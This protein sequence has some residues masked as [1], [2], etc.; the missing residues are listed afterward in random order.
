MFRESSLFTFP[1]VYQI[2]CIVVKHRF[3]QH[4]LTDFI[5]ASHTT[6]P[7]VLLK[8]NL[9]A[10]LHRRISFSRYR[11]IQRYIKGLKKIPNFISVSRHGDQYPGFQ[12]LTGNGWQYF[13]YGCTGQITGCKVTCSCRDQGH[14]YRSKAAAGMQKEIC[15]SI[16]LQ[17]ARA[18]REM[19]EPEM[20]RYTFYKVQCPSSMDSF[21]L[22]KRLNLLHCE[23][24]H[25]PVPGALDF[26]RVI[27]KYPQTAA[28]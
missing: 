12:K 24:L 5:E 3:Q 27:P 21:N 26:S 15:R 25:V 4:S 8:G 1:A 23:Q 10:L 22:G 19:T 28:A 6:I 9:R 14:L 11:R 16:F 2:C 7:C 17:K 18:K 20:S 13:G